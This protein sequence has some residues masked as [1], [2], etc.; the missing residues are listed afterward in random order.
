MQA[1]LPLIAAALALCTAP[2]CGCSMVGMGFDKYDGRW[3]ANVPPSGN[4]CPSR[5]VLD[6][7][8]HGLTGSVED[9]NGVTTVSGK[10]ADDGQA[11]LNGGGGHGSV[12]FS[13]VNF[14]A[15]IPGDRCGR[16][17]VGNRGG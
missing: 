11:A 1:R 3:V 7:D 4:C 2:L 5:V 17:V 9:C 10:V 12:Q 6:V 14:T 15:S 13:G 16:A 8:G